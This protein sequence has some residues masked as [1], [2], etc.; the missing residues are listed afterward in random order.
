MGK[1]VLAVDISSEFLHLLEVK[2]KPTYIS[3][4]LPNG[5]VTQQRLTN[6]EQFIEILKEELKALAPKHFWQ[7]RKAIMA[8]P[9]NHVIIK[10]TQTHAAMR[11]QERLEQLQ[12]LINTQTAAIAAEVCWDYTGFPSA[13]AGISEVVVAVAQQATVLAY[14]QAFA[15]CGL[16]LQVIDVESYALARAWRARYQQRILSLKTYGVLL[17]RRELITLVAI[18]ANAQLYARAIPV[19]I[20]EAY[21]TSLLRTALQLIK[22]LRFSAETLELHELY[23]AGEYATAQHA[24]LLQQ[25]LSTPVAVIEN[26]TQFLCFGLTL[27]EQDG[28]N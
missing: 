3:M 26:P 2:P 12:Q 22:G 19:E 7:Q 23:L 25:Q 10:T 1:T 11:Q 24:H 9:V 21:E 14:Q 28:K 8:L 13:Q 18:S 6:T 15:A 27:W 17:V 4:P 20:A 16:C 5:C